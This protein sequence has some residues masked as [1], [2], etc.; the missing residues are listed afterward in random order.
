MEDENRENTPGAEEPKVE[1]VKSRCIPGND[2]LMDELKEVRKDT[3][4]CLGACKEIA[5]VVGEL[6]AEVAKWR[7]AGKFVLSFS[8]TGYL[9]GAMLIA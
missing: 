2:E 8:L 7:K 4:G 9:L 5:K 3:E 1:E 6:K